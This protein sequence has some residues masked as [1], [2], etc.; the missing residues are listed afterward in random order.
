MN[1]LSMMGFYS[2]AITKSIIIHVLFISYIS[3]VMFFQCSISFLSQG[4]HL[5]EGL[6]FVL[7][8]LAKMVFVELHSEVK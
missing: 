3:I 4:G 8:S 5:I 6:I 2:S 7:K 1:I